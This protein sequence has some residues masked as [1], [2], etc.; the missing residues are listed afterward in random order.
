LRLF[1][2]A[3]CLWNWHLLT[4]DRS[5]D[6]VEVAERFADG[7]SSVEELVRAWEVAGDVWPRDRRGVSQYS[8]WVRVHRAAWQAAN[9][10]PADAAF[11]VCKQTDAQLTPSEVA[12]AGGYTSV[13]TNKK[14]IALLLDIFENPFRP[15]A[16]DPAWR[17]ETAVLLARGM[18]ESRDFSPMPILADALQDAGCDSAA[19]LD[20][21]R[22]RGPHARGCWVVDLVLGKG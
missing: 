19:V 3:C 21:C 9:P 5:R 10:T 2:V 20:H 18:Y 11:L 16:F 6:A 4:D 15:I 22:G 14:I 7:G 12:A 8:T 13:A 1:A 17:T